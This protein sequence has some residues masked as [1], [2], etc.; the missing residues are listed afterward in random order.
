MVCWLSELSVSLSVGGCEHII[1][2][3][4]TLLLYCA[5]GNSC[6]HYLSSW[7]QWVFCKLVHLAFHWHDIAWRPAEVHPCCRRTAS[8]SWFVGE[9]N[10]SFGWHFHHCLKNLI[11]NVSFIVCI[12]L[13][14]GC[15]LCI[16]KTCLKLTYT[17]KNKSKIDALISFLFSFI[18]LH[19]LTTS[20]NHTPHKQC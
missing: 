6:E 18:R 11:V 3:A 19:V 20:T 1:I 9:Q 4:W 15:D 14:S 13:L 16:C 17:S 7:L 2:V 12:T 8:V 10:Y 5:R